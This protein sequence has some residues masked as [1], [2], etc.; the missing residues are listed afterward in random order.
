MKA[1][2]FQVDAF[3]ARLFSGNPAAVV[4]LSSWP[5]DRILQAVAAENNLSE[6]AFFVL[7]AHG[8]DLRWFTPLCEVDLCGHATLAAAHVL[9]QHLAWPNPVIV[10]HTRS[11]EI[12]TWREGERIVMDFPTKNLIP[13]AM[14]PKLVAGLGV[15]PQEILATDRDYVAIY[16]DPQ[17]VL[18]IR[19]DHEVLRVLDRP[20]IAVSA[21]ATGVGEGV[22]FVSRFFA[23]RLGVP[24]DPV[25]GSAHCALAPYWAKRLGKSLL[26]ARQVSSRGG[27]IL[28][29]VGGDRVTLSGHAVTFLTGEIDL[30]VGVPVP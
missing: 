20:G 25:T 3:T 18:A 13:C 16:D 5:E 22:D 26:A 23:P 1:A 21:L 6:T 15:K 14:P 17:T 4:A 12:T 9:F 8:F 29:G 24:E 30:G 11:G 2:L 10:F 19:P 27:D 7:A 28:C